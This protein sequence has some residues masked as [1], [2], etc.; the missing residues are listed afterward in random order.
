MCSI[1]RFGIYPNSLVVG[2]G[3]SLLGSS[4]SADEH[5]LGFAGS[6]DE[7]AKLW[8]LSTGEITTYILAD[9]L[10]TLPMP[11]FPLMDTVGGTASA[12]GTV[13]VQPLEFQGLNQRLYKIPVEPPSILHTSRICL[14]I[15]Y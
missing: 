10:A 6:S 2:C 7:T 11:R 5:S 13:I 4:F 15:F 1:L 9:I 12:D 8:D 3:G 14:Y